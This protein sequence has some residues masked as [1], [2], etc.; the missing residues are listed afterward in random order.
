[1]PKVKTVKA[2]RKVPL[3]TYYNCRICETVLALETEDQKEAD[4]WFYNCPFPIK[5]YE[6]VEYAI[7]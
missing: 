2:K 4:Q 5:K 1:M 3:C 6:V 7:N